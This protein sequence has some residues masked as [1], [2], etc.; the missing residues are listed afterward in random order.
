[1]LPKFKTELT[2]LYPLSSNYSFIAKMV[3]VLLSPK[4]S[5]YKK[6]GSRYSKSLIESKNSKLKT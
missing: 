4:S 6:T 5:S 2:E 3:V 1:M